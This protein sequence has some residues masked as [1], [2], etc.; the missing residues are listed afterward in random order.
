MLKHFVTVALIAFA[1]AP[2][3]IA[4]TSDQTSEVIGEV[5]SIDPKNQM[6]MVKTSDGTTKTV[7]YLAG[8]VD[9][10]KIKQGDTVTLGYKKAIPGTIVSA[11]RNYVVVR[12]DNNAGADRII[13]I[14]QPLNPYQ[15]GDRVAILSKDRI[16][17]IPGDDLYLSN[18]DVVEYVRY[19]VPAIAYSETRQVTVESLPRS[20]EAAQPTTG[21][22]G[23]VEAP[24]AEQSVA[25]PVRALW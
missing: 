20:T 3:A 10:E 15:I 22:T 5:E 18:G 21:E 24:A 14:Q 23:Q 19:N 11:F 1:I 2:M 17:K 8:A 9:S 13:Y 25:R 6:L 4:Q 16:A 12:P 7:R